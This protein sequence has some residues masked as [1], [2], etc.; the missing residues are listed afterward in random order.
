MA[1]S[2]SGIKGDKGEGPAQQ[3]DLDLDDGDAV[4]AQ[5]HA[6]VPISAEHVL[7]CVYEE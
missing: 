4:P 7:Q 1:Y 5:R 3:P 6:A 2:A